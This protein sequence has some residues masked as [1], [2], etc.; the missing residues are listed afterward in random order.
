MANGVA[1]AFVIEPTPADSPKDTPIEITL[2]EAVAAAVTALSVGINDYQH[3]G[4]LS[5]EAK[6]IG[7]RRFA[8]VTMLALASEL[9][10]HEFFAQARAA[11][12]RELLRLFPAD[13]NHSRLEIEAVLDWHIDG[14][15]E[16]VGNVIRDERAMAN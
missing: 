9:G 2:G 16:I 13:F 10:D 8:K 1:V 11:G 3:H 5:P 6:D 15:F 14:V 7:S 12:K 4:E